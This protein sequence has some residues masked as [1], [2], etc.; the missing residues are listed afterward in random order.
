[1]RVAQVG[2]FPMRI[3]KDTDTRRVGRIA[4]GAGGEQIVL[5]VAIE[6]RRSFTGIGHMLV[7]EMDAILA[8]GAQI[9]GC[10]LGTDEFA[11]WTLEPHLALS[12]LGV[13]PHVLVAYTETFGLQ[14]LHIFVWSREAVGLHDDE[15]AVGIHRLNPAYPLARYLII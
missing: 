13:L 1:M 4:R 6:V 2:I 10:Q 9:V 8:V 12:C 15:I 3:G 5:A 11:M 14:A 7:G